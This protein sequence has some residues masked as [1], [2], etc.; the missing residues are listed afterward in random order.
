M[1]QTNISTCNNLTISGLLTTSNNI[2]ST[3]TLQTTAI[4]ST[5][6]SNSGTITSNII[7][8]T[9]ANLTSLSISSLLTLLSNTP[10]SFNYNGSNYNLSSLMLYTL[11]QLSGLPIASQSYVQTQISNLINSSPALLD[12]LSELSNAINNDPNFNNTMLNLIATKA[13]LT[14]NNNF[15]GTTNTFSNLPY[16]VNT[17]D[18]LILY[19]MVINIILMLYRYLIYFNYQVQV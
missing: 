18:Q 8:G 2:L 13:G 9:T 7:N 15:T 5:G 11:Q 14:S 12:T 10:I 6:I 17:S 3:G 19:I 4:S 1:S 16:F